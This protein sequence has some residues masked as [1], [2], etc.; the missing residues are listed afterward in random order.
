M[1]KSLSRKVEHLPG[2]Y[3]EHFTGLI[4][5]EFKTRNETEP[6]RRDGGVGVRRN[7]HLQVVLQMPIPAQIRELIIYIG[8]SKG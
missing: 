3:L 1:G 7:G 4:S 6:V 8:N 2:H 5:P